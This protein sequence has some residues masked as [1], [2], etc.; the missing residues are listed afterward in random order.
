MSGGDNILFLDFDGVI[1]S[2]RTFYLYDRPQGRSTW[3]SADPLVIEMLNRLSGMH[4]IRVVISS[5]WRM[6][7][8]RP[9]TAPEG[10]YDHDAR[11]SLRGW[12][13]TGRIHD[14]WRT[15]YLPRMGDDG[16][17]ENRDRQIEILAWIYRHRD[18]IQHYACLDDL[19]MDEFMNPVRSDPIDGMNRLWQMTLA[20]RYISG[21]E[22]WT[23]SDLVDD[24]MFGKWLPEQ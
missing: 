16:D 9:P 21:M 4:D 10:D 3:T 24:D 2:A 8:I 22:G 15:P 20:E 14:D 17:R 18:G 19:P 7:H 1:T 5:T 6:D 13:Y 23:V 12:G 11:D